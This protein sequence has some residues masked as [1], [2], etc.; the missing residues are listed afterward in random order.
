MQE[1][2]KILEAVIFVSEEPVAIEEIAQKLELNIYELQEA[3]E[4]IK[5]KYSNGGVILKEVAG[6]Y[7]FYTS[8]E[9]S[10]YVKKFV[11]DKPI[12]LSKH[13]LEVLAIIAY[14]QPI[15]KKEIETIRGRTADG[16]I[17]SL[18]EK[19]LIQV[20]GRKKGPGRPKL[21]G[22]TDDFLVHFGLR[23]IQDLPSVDLEEI[24]EEGMDRRS[25]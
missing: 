2:E 10:S 12:K 25:D 9:V 19:R 8:P 13:L 24:F 11:E 6:G 4:H 14:K 16:A 23:S 3:L 22:T 17:K 21:Y 20:V 1:I 5:G 18:L 15:T 7:K